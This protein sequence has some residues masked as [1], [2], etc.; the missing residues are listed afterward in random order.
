[1]LDVSNRMNRYLAAF[2]ISIESI[3]AR[4]LRACKEATSLERAEIGADG[5]DHLLVPAA[6]EAWR[7]LKAAALV[8]GISLFIGSAF[9]SI[10]RQAEIVR[11]KLENGMDVH[12]ILAICAPPGFSEHHT[13]RAVGVSTPGS[14]ALEVEF[15]QRTAY[16]WLAKR[17]AEF[18]RLSYPSVILGVSNVSLGTGVSTTPN[19]A[20]QRTCGERHAIHRSSQRAA[21]RGQRVAGTPSPQLELNPHAV[22]PPPRCAIQL[23][24]L[25]QFGQLFAAGEDRRAGAAGAGARRP[26]GEGGVPPGRSA[27]AAGSR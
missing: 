11:G 3:T 12:D 9:R 4:G 15:D 18:G 21:A 22:W 1:M 13:G 23:L 27:A 8:D 16:A 2:G 26:S 7:N 14:H 19:L 10:D 6:A 20:A 17:A 5:R 24:Q 25:L